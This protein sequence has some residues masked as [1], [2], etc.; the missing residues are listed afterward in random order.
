MCLPCLQGEFVRALR[1]APRK[2]NALA[3]VTTGMRVV[4]PEGSSLVQDLS[5]YYGGVGPCTISATKTCS[6]VIGR[7]DQLPVIIKLRS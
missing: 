3:T 4:F 2:E 5:L 7:Y 6:A 1:Q